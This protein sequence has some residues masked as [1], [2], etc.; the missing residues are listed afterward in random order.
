MPTHMTQCTLLCVVHLVWL[1]SGRRRAAHFALAC[2][3]LH[4]RPEDPQRF[5]WHTLSKICWLHH[6]YP[7][8]PNHHL[9]IIRR[10]P[11]TSNVVAPRRVFVDIC[12]W[13]PPLRW[14]MP[15]LNRNN[16]I[17]HARSPAIW[18]C[19]F[20]TDSCGQSPFPLRRRM[21][22]PRPNKQIRK[23][24]RHQ[25]LTILLAIRRVSNITQLTYTRLQIKDGVVG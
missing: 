3:R 9:R 1:C 24:N 10:T 13:F 17:L 12:W 11:C 18:R 7:N 19:P 22:T 16:Q 15:T 20:V 4:K 5:R 2:L 23:R 21:P 8:V 14:L 6:S 25:A